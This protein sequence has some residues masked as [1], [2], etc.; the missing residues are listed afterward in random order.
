MANLAVGALVGGNIVGGLIGGRASSR[1]A[2][3]QQAA[4]A[5][6]IGEERRQFD[7]S[8]ADIAP[9]RAA[10][11]NALSR[12]EYLLGTGQTPDVQTAQAAVDQ[13]QERLNQLSRGTTKTTPVTVMTRKMGSGHSKGDWTMVPTTIQQ[14]VQ[15]PPD[16]NAVAKAQS[17]LQTARNALSQASQA[18]AGQDYGS[19]LRNFTNEDFRTAPGYEFR[20]GEGQKAIERSAA[21]RG[22]QLSGAALKGLT[23]Y[24]QDFASNEFQNAYNRDLANRQTT[25]NMLAGVS[26]TGQT[27]ATNI[28]QMGQQSAGNIADYYLQGGN[29]RAAGIM[30]R[31]NAL[32]G[33]IQDVAQYYALQN[34][35]GRR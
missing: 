20:L 23:R 30:G 11:V 17:D 7:V 5:Q 10:G 6:A 26:G 29:A 33:G 27:A 31:G 1:A 14:T 25:Y 4:S 19:L 2:S 32:A 35:L 3:A 8:R 15:V 9:W 21:A 12:L 13:A 22:N 34:L 16:P 18:P 24:G 28:A